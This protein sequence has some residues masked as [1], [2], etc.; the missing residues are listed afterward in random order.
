[1]QLNTL[2]RIGMALMQPKNFV[3]SLET[4]RWVYENTTSKYSLRGFI[5]AIF[6][7]RGPPVTTPGYFSDANAK[8]GISRDASVFTRVLNEV[9]SGN[10]QG[11]DGYN[12]PSQFAEHHMADWNIKYKPDGKI[13]REKSTKMVFRTL[14]TGGEE[15]DWS[16]V[17]YTLPSFLVFEDKWEDV[18]DMHFITQEMAVRDGQEVLRQIRWGN[19]D[20]NV[21]LAWGLKFEVWKTRTSY[22]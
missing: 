12:L 14:V 17:E 20:E 6:C 13:D 19:K 10:P 7:Q 4:V 1:M 22:P 11:M 5:I 21:I 2:M 16:K 18:P 8:L 9:R 15:V 3:Y